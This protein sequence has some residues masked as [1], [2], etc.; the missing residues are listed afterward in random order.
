MKRTLAVLLFVGALVLAGQG[1]FAQPTL[2]KGRNI[3]TA[4]VNCLLANPV[5]VFSHNTERLSISIENVGT[6][7]VV[8]W[9]SSR[10]E[11]QP[12]TLHAGATLSLDNYVGSL[13]CRAPGTVQL[14]IL[15]ETR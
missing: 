3:S 7:H 15:E 1:V 14:Q 10:G 2:Q 4:N 13:D 12:F 9:N 6:T 8:L 11:A 5:N